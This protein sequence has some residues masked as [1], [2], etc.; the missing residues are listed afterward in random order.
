VSVHRL[1]PFPISLESL[2]LPSAHAHPES[3]PPTNATFFSFHFFFLFF[4][5]FYFVFQE[6]SV[7]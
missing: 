7:K 2:N 3:V 6:L 4:V 5:L 1:P